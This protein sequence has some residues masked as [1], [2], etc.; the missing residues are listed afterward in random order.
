MLNS[1]PNRRW[2]QVLAEY[3]FAFEGFEAPHVELTPIDR[4]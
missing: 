4:G 2:S 3:R 1:P